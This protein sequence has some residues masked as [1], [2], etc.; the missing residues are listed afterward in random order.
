M[1]PPLQNGFNI[2]NQRMTTS[3]TPPIAS[4]SLPR[5]GEIRAA[6]SLLLAGG[7]VEPPYYRADYITGLTVVVDDLRWELPQSEGWS[8]LSPLSF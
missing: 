6:I 7:M 2:I 3:P 8:A 5:D 1:L 4:S